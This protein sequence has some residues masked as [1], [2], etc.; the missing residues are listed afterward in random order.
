MRSNI[1]E[2]Y[3]YISNYTYVIFIYNY[4]CIYYISFVYFYNCYIISYILDKC[5]FVRLSNYFL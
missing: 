2:I 1:T 4:I 5:N 3:Y